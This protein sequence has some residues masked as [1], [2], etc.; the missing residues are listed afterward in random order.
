ML[1]SVLDEAAID[2][3]GGSSTDTE[4]ESDFGLVVYQLFHQYDMDDMEHKSDDESL[5]AASHTSINGQDDENDDDTT[6]VDT[7]QK[8]SAGNET[9]ENEEAR[10]QEEQRQRYEDRQELDQKILFD[11]Q[12]DFVFEWVSTTKLYIARPRTDPT[13]K[14]AIKIVK[15]NQCRKKDYFPME[16][17]VLS[18]IRRNA[19]LSKNLQQLQ[20]FLT[21]P[22]GYAF[23]SPFAENL[24]DLSKHRVFAQSP[25]EIK[26]IMRELLLAIDSLHNMNVI[27]RDIKQSNILWQNN[28][29][30]LIDY[31]LATWNQQG[32][33]H[34]AVQGTLGYIAPEILQFERD[35]QG[36]PKFYNNK[37]DIYSAGV[38]FGSLLLN[39]PEN[40]VTEI[41]VR[42]FREH[43]HAL[44]P[45]DPF[46]VNLLL[47]MIDLNPNSRPPA[48]TLL[49]HDYFLY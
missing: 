15:D 7:K 33:K 16:L 42:A 31:D 40:D 23:F 12:N 45:N 44:I 6:P 24:C 36:T 21:Q 13:K 9:K 26:R 28:V 38:V 8:I 47:L 29:L 48:H 37:I 41:Y 19:L 14:W 11:L 32:R 43:A 18:H 20:C 30:T 39:V 49:K 22:N 5:V 46:A 25:Q 4:E 17:R 27:H 3:N 35:V 10:K 2:A 1:Q 34:I